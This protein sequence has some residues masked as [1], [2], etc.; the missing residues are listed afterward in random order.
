MGR[1]M[2]YKTTRNSLRNQVLGGFEIK[3]D[4]KYNEKIIKKYFISED[5]LT[6]WEKDFYSSVKK[7]DFN[8]TDKQYS[9]I[10]LIYNKYNN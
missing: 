5:K 4:K 9:I 10:Y 7:Q 1:K 6:D 3:G 8:I 2:D